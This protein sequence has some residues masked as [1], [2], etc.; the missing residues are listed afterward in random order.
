MSIGRK[1]L[2]A[3][4]VLATALTG[5]GEAYAAKLFKGIVVITARTNTGLC[6][7]EYD[8]SESFVVEY[9][10]NVGAETTPERLSIMSTNGSLLLSNA[11]ATPTLRGA[12]RVSVAGNIFAR[13]V[14]IPSINTQFSISAVVANTVT[15]TMSGTANS[16]GIPGCNV[17]I[18]GAL[19]YLPPGGY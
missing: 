9:L 11:D 4:V 16:L 19:T 10:A 3:S 15:V 1:S 14:A 18:R 6:M 17:T 8:I 2:L 5:A 12:G 7:A 13:P